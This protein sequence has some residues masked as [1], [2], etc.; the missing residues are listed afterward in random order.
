M[1]EPIRN[2]LVAE[3]VPEAQFD[4]L[5]LVLAQGGQGPMGLSLPLDLVQALVW[6]GGTQL[7]GPSHSIV[8]VKSRIAALSRPGSIQRAASSYRGQEGAQGPTIGIKTLRASP[9]LEED[10]FQDL[11]RIFGGSQDSHAD[12]KDHA[13]M[14]AVEAFERLGV[15]IRDGSRQHPINELGARG[16][17]GAANSTG[18][19]ERLFRFQVGQASS[20]DHETCRK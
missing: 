20:V 3:T 9:Q 4:D 2:L 14:S 13:A 18:Q 11:F 6:A 1:A 12:P 10:I 16:P 17:S 8:G 5:S 15:A 19:N 7:D